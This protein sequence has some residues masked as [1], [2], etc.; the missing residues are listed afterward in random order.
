MVR[1]PNLK[2]VTNKPEAQNENKRSS[3]DKIGHLHLFILNY[4]IVM[5][6]YFGF[7][8]FINLLS[9]VSLSLEIYRVTIHLL[10]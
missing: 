6:F 3:P 4:L 1:G 10:G 9:G 8:I 2:L 7:F 5:R